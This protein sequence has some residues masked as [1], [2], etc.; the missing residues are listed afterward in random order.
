MQIVIFTAPTAVENEVI[1]LHQF[2]ADSKLFLHVR[3]P[4]YSKQEL[5]CFLDQLDDKFHPQVVIHQHIELLDR[6]NLKGFHCTRY[7]LENSTEKLEE[8]KSRFP[9]KTF[10]KS[11][12]SLAEMKIREGYDYVFLSPIFNSIS[13]GNYPS[14]F[15]LDEANKFIKISKQKVIALGGVSKAKLPLL[16]NTNFY[17]VAFLG[18]IWNSKNPISEYKTSSMI[19]NSI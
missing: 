14:K 18:A 6:Y 2:L 17:G 15:D 19:V 12:H 11:C 5:V 10:S 7:F 3:K 13:K 16:K 1:L 8:L 9:K 4:N